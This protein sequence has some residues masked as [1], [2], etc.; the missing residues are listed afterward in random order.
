MCRS[1][2]EHKR[3]PTHNQAQSYWTT[4]NTKSQKERI[5]SDFWASQGH[6]LTIPA[7]R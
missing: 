4:E 3:H 6:F 1:T 2:K 7:K 5:L